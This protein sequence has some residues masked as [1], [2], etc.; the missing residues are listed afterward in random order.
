MKRIDCR[1]LD[2]KSIKDIN[3]YIVNNNDFYVNISNTKGISSNMLMKLDPRVK[4]RVAGGYDDYKVSQMGNDEYI[5]FN[6]YTRNKLIN[7][8]KK[9]EELEKGIKSNWNDYQKLIYF[10]NNLKRSIYYDPKYET[11]KSYD[12]RSLRGLL[13]GET[14]CAGYAMI[15]KELLDRQGISCHYVSCVIPSGEGHAFNIVEINGNNYP[16]DLTWD[17][18]KYSRGNNKNN[19]FLACDIEEFKK[20]HKLKSWEKVNY[21]NHPLSSLDINY[22]NNI[23][24]RM[25]TEMILDKETFVL[26]DKDG[27]NYVVSQLGTNVIN[28]SSIYRYL[29]AKQRSNG[30]YG[31]PYIVY[32]KTNIAQLMHDKNWSVDV[33]KQKEK[34]IGILFSSDNI[35]D[36]L[37]NNTCYIGE[38]KCYKGIQRKFIGDISDVVKDKS[39]ANILNYKTVS[40]VRKDGS[41]FVIQRTK[42]VPDKYNNLEFYSFD[43]VEV[44]KNENGKP[45]VKKNVVFSDTDLLNVNINDISDTILSRSHIDKCNGNY[46]GY[47]G[48]LDNNGN[49]K[50]NETLVKFFKSNQNIYF[51]NKNKKDKQDKFT[52]AFPKIS[53]LEDLALKYSFDF[54]DIDNPKPDYDSFICKDIKTGEVI[55]DIELKRKIMLAHLWIS[56]AGKRVYADDKIPGMKE[57]FLDIH[58]KSYDNIIRACFDSVKKNN[59]YI[60]T[61]DVLNTIGSDNLRDYMIVIKL[62]R[63]QFQAMMINDMIRA[64]FGIFED[65]DYD[66]QALYNES[67]AASLVNGRK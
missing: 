8:I 23:S 50:Y 57:A 43:I 18:G 15:L 53:E 64:H 34:A 12:I 49:I 14:V 11:K 29:Y 51:E 63:T 47:I 28:G 56:C 27:S 4:I 55:T 45:I 66:S 5:T 41:R 32:S 37:N 20:V 38:C 17:S 39:L 25:N 16:V 1:K 9:I 7:I 26:K 58:K 13:T 6:I 33:N 22:V 42:K 31:S 19:N 3:D 52:M 65:L 10:Y 30:E 62:F 40:A 35:T 59:G 36:S 61:V 44:I 60:D 46:D 48:Y 2:E 24:F 54:V 67:Y 21:Q